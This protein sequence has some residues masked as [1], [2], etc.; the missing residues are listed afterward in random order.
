VIID[1]LKTR[2]SRRKRLCIL[3]GA[4]V[5]LIAL[6]VLL[7]GCVTISNINLGGNVPAGSNHLISMTLTATSDAASPVRGVFAV[8]IPAAW[9]VNAVSFSGAMTGAAT[10]S[11]AMEAVYSTEWEMTPG[12]GHNGPKAG[13]KWWVGYSAASTWTSGQASTVTISIDTHAMGGTYYLDFA[14]GV[15]GEA[16]PENPADTGLWQI[17]SAGDAPTGMSLDQAIT[18]FCF[19]DVTPGAAYYEA[20]QGMG[21]KGIIQGYANIPPNGYYEF[22]P[23]NTVYRAQYAKMIDGALGLTVEEAMAEPV[24]FTDLGADVLPGP[25]VTN[26]LYPH[27]YV[28]V[29]YNNNIIKGYD[30]GTFK[31][32]TAISRGHVITMTVRALL[33]LHPDA[34][35]PAPDSFVQTWGNDL[36]PVHKAN[37]RIAEYNNL[38]AGLP[39]TTTAA[40][41]NAPMPRG[42]VAQ[43]LWNMMDLIGS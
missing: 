18:L 15:A 28:W 24:H 38:L 30:D 7:G 36:L 13:Y 20:I 40:N 8:R 33:N 12:P 39:L 34:L 37:A 4:A 1:S 23:S 43:V 5:L 26:S 11:A 41:G 17:G 3:A 16:T 2:S 42:E 35:Q 21:A 29:A 27:E 25:G 19:T 9:D 14:T 31:P 6:A 32:Y 10:E 22:R